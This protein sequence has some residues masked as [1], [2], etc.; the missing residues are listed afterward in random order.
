M[1]QDRNVTSTEFQNHAGHC[2]DQAAK[3]PV[4]ITRHRRPSRVLLDIEEYGR[5][6]RLDTRQALF[7]TELNDEDR[8][9]IRHADYGS[10]DRHLDA[11]ME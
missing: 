10:G 3:A 6:K 5:L 9:L 7:A 1:A 8:E 2:L 4:F 11:L